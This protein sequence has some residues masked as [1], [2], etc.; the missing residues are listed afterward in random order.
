MWGRLVT[1]GGLAI[2]LVAYRSNAKRRLPTGAQD[3]I[4]PHTLVLRHE[5]G[6]ARIGAQHGQGRFVADL[7]YRLAGPQRGADR[8]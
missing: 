6:V 1:C 3:S 8:R 4:L 2:R 5:L 7:L